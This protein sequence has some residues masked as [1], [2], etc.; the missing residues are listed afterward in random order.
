MNSRLEHSAGGVV[1]RES[2]VLVIRVT[3]LQGKTVVTF[4]KGH[5]EP[6]ETPEQAALREVHEE[7][8]I[9]AQ[10]T[11]PLRETSYHF[12]KDGVLVRKRVT[13]FLMEPIGETDPARVPRTAETEEAYWVPLEDIEHQLSYPL[14][15][16]LV[17]LVKGTTH[18]QR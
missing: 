9:E 3:N 14:D 17:K 1:L 15:R 7:T 4:P 16:E 6:G 11:R 13:W 10:I 5:I 12:V 18:E 2:S 8:G